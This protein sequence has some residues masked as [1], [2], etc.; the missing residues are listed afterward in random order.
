MKGILLAGGMGTRLYPVTRVASKHLICIYDKPMIYY[1]LS[2]L[3][4]AGIDD[5][6]LIST[7]S[8]SKL[9][10]KLLGDGRQFGIHLTY[11]VQKKPGGI[12]QAFLVSEDY[13]RNQHV[14]LMLGDNIF[15]GNGLQSILDDHKNMKKGA[16]IF[17]YQVKDP[18]RYG[19]LEFDQY[20]NVA[21]IQEKPK[22]PK[23]NYAIPGLYFY[24][25]QV[26][27]MAKNLRP[28]SRGELEISD[29]NR[30]YLAKK[31]LYV[32][33]MGR[34]IAWLDT[35]TPQSLLEASGFVAAVENRQ[36]LKIACLEEIAYRKNFISRR[37]L[38]ATIQKMPSGEY[39]KY[40]LSVLEEE[41]K[42]TNH[43]L[44]TVN[45]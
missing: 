43:G 39:R 35:G 34:G 38:E 45:A 15:F 41:S 27:D 20:N 28:S 36:G 24:D 31:Q 8:D 33:I 2:T 3:M 40:L 6:I 9:F 19:V 26:L 18:E 11:L 23:S 44:L 30:L 21:G 25:D 12:A 7:A 5:I 4:L 14:A 1:S 37:D 10:Q 17:G 22:E 32:K 16:M 29:I 42:N 13:I